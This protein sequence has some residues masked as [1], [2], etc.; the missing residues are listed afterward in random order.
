MRLTDIILL[1][2]QSY[3]G[4]GLNCDL[5][6]KKK[7]NKEKPNCSSSL[8]VLIGQSLK[9]KE[10]KKIRAHIAWHTF[11]IKVTMYPFLRKMLATAFE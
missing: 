5:I 10:K 3:K 1:S 9:R 2:L 4:H 7:E 6:L 11:T 8:N